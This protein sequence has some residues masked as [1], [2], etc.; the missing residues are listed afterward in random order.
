[1]ATRADGWFAVADGVLSCC[2]QT[3]SHALVA[4]GSRPSLNSMWSMI[5]SI[6]LPVRPASMMR[7]GDTAV[8]SSRY[9]RKRFQMWQSSSVRGVPC[10]CANAS[11]SSSVPPVSGAFAQCGVGTAEEAK[12]ADVEHKKLRVAEMFS[13]LDRQG[14]RRVPPELVE[15][16]AE[17][18]EPTNLRIKPAQTGDVGHNPQQFP[19]LPRGQNKS[20]VPVESVLRCCDDQ[21]PR[22]ENQR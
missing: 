1:M 7:W 10:V 12:A 18:N 6:G 4:T 8:R 5:V 20:A 3:E 15:H 2:G 16:P 19:S 14:A 17:I 13:I 21:R 22:Y 9:R 11:T